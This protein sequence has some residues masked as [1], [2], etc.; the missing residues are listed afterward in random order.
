MLEADNAIFINQQESRHTPELKEI[1]FLPINICHTMLWIGQTD[2]RQVFADPVTLESFRAIRAYAEDNCVTR[3]EGRILI[4]QTRK[5]GA[6]IRSHKTAQ[7]NQ[8]HIF[9]TAEIKQA[10]ILAVD[11]SQF[12]IRRVLQFISHKHPILSQSIH[13]ESG[14]QGT[15]ASRKLTV[16]SLVCRH[17]SC[18]GIVAGLS[19]G[20]GP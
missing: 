18:A 2:K 20:W 6:T 1:P 8:Q 11:I 10:D 12:K 5:M 9:V 13:S 3:R 16:A 19:P 4:A 15:S 14:F 17:C 7:E